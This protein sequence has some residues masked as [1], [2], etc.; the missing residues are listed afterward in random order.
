MRK[1]TIYS[2]LASSLLFSSYNLASDFDIIAHRGASGYLPEHTLE[3]ATLAFAQQPDFIEQDVVAT[4]D[5][6]PIVLHDIHLDTV[7][8]V[9][10]VYPK[11]ARSD[12]RYYAVDFTLSEL[13]RLRVHE[14]TDRKGEQVFTSRYQ[15]QHANFTV[16]TFAEH[17]ELITELNRQFSTN[18]GVYPEIKSPAWH[19]AQGIDIS[20]LVLSTLKRFNFA[21]PNANSYVQSFDFDELKRL[22]NELGYK[23]KLVLL[24]GENSWQESA[25]DFN[26]IRSEAGMREAAKYVDG[27]GPWLGHIIDT[28][29]LKQGT[30][31][32]QPWLA[33]AH[34]QQL[35]LHPYTFRKDA[36]LPGISEEELLTILINTVKADGVFTDHIPPVKNRLNTNR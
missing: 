4:K 25:T 20:A 18:I 8:N 36:L 28:N 19:Q 5:G 30:V 29:A 7:T 21:G 32:A 35:L 12:G 10:T 2:L 31:K 14:R 16:A 26:Y 6:V 3:A 13:R 23:G 17:L 22:R 15:G 33:F 27:I 1:R 24:I 34:E 11:R 9:E